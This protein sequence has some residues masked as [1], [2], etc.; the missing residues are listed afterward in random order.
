MSWGTTVECTYDAGAGTLHMRGHERGGT[1]TGG[2]EEPCASCHPLMAVLCACG[3]GCV[4]VRK[5]LRHWLIC[6]VFG[7]IPACVSL[8]RRGI[9]RPALRA[10]VRCRRACCALAVVGGSLWL[11][12]SCGAVCSYVVVNVCGH[13]R[14]NRLRI[15][16]DS[17]PALVDDDEFEYDGGTYSE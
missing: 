1:Y 7:G 15:I 11:I 8:A 13:E 4:W 12:S 14:L 5:G 16:D 6:C 3:C 17:S 9:L 2:H 10:T